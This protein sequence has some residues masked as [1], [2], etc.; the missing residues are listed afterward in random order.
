MR[1]VGKVG[2]SS[3]LVSMRKDELKAIIGP[4]DSRAK[5]V[6]KLLPVGSRF[7]V[8]STFERTSKTRKPKIIESSKLL[9]G[10]NLARIMDLYP[11]DI[12]YRIKLTGEKCYIRSFGAVDDKTILKDVVVSV[13]LVLNE[14]AKMTRKPKTTVRF[15]VKLT[16]LEPWKSEQ[17][18]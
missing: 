6:D 15:G 12:E 10:Y 9:I 2:R 16:D 5:D 3:Y 1:M 8:R 13:F 7:Q 4:N 17:E 11:I 18:E 14:K